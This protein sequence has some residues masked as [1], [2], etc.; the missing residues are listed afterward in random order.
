MRAT[1]RSWDSPVANSHQENRDLSLTAARNWILPTTWMSLE[2]DSS[3]VSPPNEHA[4]WLTPWLYPCM[5]LSTEHIWAVPGLVIY[6]NCEITN[7]FCFKPLLVATVCS[8]R[9]LIS[10][11]R[12]F[13]V[14]F[15]PIYILK[16]SYEFLI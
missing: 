10:V 16:S 1:S 4:A 8:N 14:I 13:L 11:I 12:F 2:I 15:I 3:L 9:K 5:T 6:R 7:G